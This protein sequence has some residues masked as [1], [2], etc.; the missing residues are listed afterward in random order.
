MAHSFLPAWFLKGSFHNKLLLTAWVLV[1]IHFIYIYYL[2]FKKQGRW[3]VEMRF[4]L[5]WL[6]GTTQSSKPKL[7]NG[8]QASFSIPWPWIPRMVSNSSVVRLHKQLS[9]SGSRRCIA[10]NAI[11][12]THCSWNIY[13]GFLKYPRGNPSRSLQAT[14][15]SLF[16]NFHQKMTNYIYIEGPSLLLSEFHMYIN[17]ASFS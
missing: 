11:T 17:Q 13:V 14:H 6:W 15:I 7:W 8:I 5:A 12:L 9:A 3:Q 4:F 2:I 10:S 1:C 16:R